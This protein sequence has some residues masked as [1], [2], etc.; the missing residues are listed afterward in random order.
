MTGLSGAVRTRERF[1]AL[2]KKVDLRIVRVIPTRMNDHTHII[3]AVPIASHETRDNHQNPDRSSAKNHSQEEL[4]QF[5]NG[6]VKTP[7]S[8]LG[9]D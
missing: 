4:E 8:S 5:A 2:L 9:T 6:V 3:E 7:V 1:E